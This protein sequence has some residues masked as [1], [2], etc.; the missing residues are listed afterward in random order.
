MIENNS[1]ERRFPTKE[2]G[3]RLLRIQE[4]GATVEDLEWLSTMEK[5]W[6]FKMSGNWYCITGTVE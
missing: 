5:A 6:K 4:D 3:E 2:E 1:S